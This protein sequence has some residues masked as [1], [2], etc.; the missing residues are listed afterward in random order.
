MNERKL[1]L[2]A[3]SALG[4]Y[5]KARHMRQTYERYTILDRVV[6]TAGHFTAEGFREQLLQAG[7]VISLGTVYNTF[8]VLC[9]AG[10]LR[11]HIFA[12][13][14]AMYER[15]LPTTAN[16]GHLHLICTRCNGVREIKNTEDTLRLQQRHYAS[17][18][19]AFVN[20]YV[21][22]LCAKCRRAAASRAKTSGNKESGRADKTAKR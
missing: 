3:R 4:Q 6:V 22:G 9:D 2:E 21:Y 19:A 1:Q 17:F 16:A 5:L 15:T 11:R 7:E 20:I 13:N 12:D 14:R 8:E 18:K 10:L